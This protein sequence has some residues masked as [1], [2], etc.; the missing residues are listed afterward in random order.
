[1]I[2]KSRRG[3][4][5]RNDITSEVARMAGGEANAPDSRDL[6]HRGEQLG[7]AALALRIAVAI[8]VLAQELD[9]RIAQVGDA[10]RLI[11]NGT[12]GTAALFAARE[13][14]YAIGAEL[15][16]SL[17]D[18]DVA[19]VRVLAGREFGFESLL[20]LAVVQAGN[21]RLTRLKPRQHLRQAA[22]RSRTGN[23]RDIG[24]AVEDFFAL[25]LGH[26]AQHAET[27]T[28]LV[29]CLVVIEAVED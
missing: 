4:D 20:G 9:F 18:G 29:Q 23:Q 8:H 21:A 7:E 24:R 14:H 11:E 28:C 16:A 26:A 5:G 6:G 27:L 13:R 25:L 15:V 19:A 1:M 3:V 17:D 2:A 22:V 12:R 10:P